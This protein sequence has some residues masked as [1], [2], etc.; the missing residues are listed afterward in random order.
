[1]DSE[2]TVMKYVFGDETAVNIAETP[3]GDSGKWLGELAP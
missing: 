3:N 1:M 2:L